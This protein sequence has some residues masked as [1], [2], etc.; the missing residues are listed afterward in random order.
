MKKIIISVVVTLLL[1]AGVVS[2]SKPVSDT[3]KQ[4]TITIMKAYDPG[5][6]GS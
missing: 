1:M 6:G 5:G 4:E 3:K 2:V